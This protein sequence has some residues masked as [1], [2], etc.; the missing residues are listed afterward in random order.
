LNSNLVVDVY[1]IGVLLFVA[2]FAA[3]RLSESFAQVMGIAKQAIRVV[4]DPDLDD[5]AKERAARDS[6][7]RLLIQSVTITVKGALTVASALLPFW[8][9]SALELRSWDE[10]IEFSLRWDVLGLTTLVM[11]GLWL[12]WHR[13]VAARS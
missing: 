6:A 7:W 4:G 10:M 5:D 12:L 1:I 2:T 3:T 8:V 9:A 11:C 13:W